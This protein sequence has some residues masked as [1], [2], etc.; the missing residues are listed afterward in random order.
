MRCEEPGHL[1][2]FLALIMFLGFILIHWPY[3]VRFCIEEEHNLVYVL[4]NVMYVV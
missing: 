1:G 3:T 2:P 4:K